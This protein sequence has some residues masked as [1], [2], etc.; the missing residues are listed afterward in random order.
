MKKALLV[1]TVLFLLVQAACVNDKYIPEVVNN[2]CDTTYYSRVIK[3]IIITNC[4]LSGCHDGHSSI[5]NF[6]NYQEVKVEI[7]EEEDH[8]SEF[9]YRLKKPFGAPGHMPVNSVLS[10]SEIHLIENWIN[11]GYAG[12]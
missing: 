2:Q 11:S 10:P 4:T 9:L 3:P 8:E 6:N 12:C 1:F 5:P 7:E